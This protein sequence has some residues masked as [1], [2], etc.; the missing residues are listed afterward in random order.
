MKQFIKRGFEINNIKISMIVLIF[1]LG[2]L[3]SGITFLVS[4]QI[5]VGLPIRFGIFFTTVVL[6]AVL[7]NSIVAVFLYKV[8]VSS[9]RRVVIEIK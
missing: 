6:P 7:L 2:T 8:V 5:L 4:A 3:I 1:T 9:L